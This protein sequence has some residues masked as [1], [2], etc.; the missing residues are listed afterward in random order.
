MSR[1]AT[2]SE[3]QYC[4]PVSSANIASAAWCSL[5]VPCDSK[6]RNQ[7]PP[8][9]SSCGVGVAGKVCVRRGHGCVGTGGS[10]HHPSALNLPLHPHYSPTRPAP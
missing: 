9:H 4:S 3:W 7:S 5:Y 2:P 10:P 1:C 8:S 6:R